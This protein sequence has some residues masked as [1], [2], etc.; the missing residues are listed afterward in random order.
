MKV[1]VTVGTT[2]FTDLI[3]KVDTIKGLEAV[4]QISNDGYVP[5]NYKFYDF[6]EDIDTYYNWADVVITHAGAGSVYQLLELDKKVII[7]PNLSRVDSHQ[8]DIANY[9]EEMQYALVCYDLNELEKSI[10]NISSF[11][12]VPYKSD[13]FNKSDEIM[14]FLGK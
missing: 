2:I 13:P 1:F 3:K 4:M 10:S 12:K 9:M 8:I 14:G 7:I 11:D 5:K 6:C